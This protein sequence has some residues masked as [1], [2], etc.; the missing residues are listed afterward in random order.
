MVFPVHLR[1]LS[2][3]TS[4]L[5]ISTARNRVGRQTSGCGH[6]LGNENKACCC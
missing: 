5:E 3:L 1:V 4:L 2:M 6:I